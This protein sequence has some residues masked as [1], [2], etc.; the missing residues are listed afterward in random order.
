M[1]TLFD[2]LFPLGMF[3]LGWIIVSWVLYMEF[4]RVNKEKTLGFF[5][6][7]CIVGGCI[8][9]VIYGF[10]LLYIFVIYCIK[11][12]YR[13]MMFFIYVIILFVQTILNAPYWLFTEKFWV[14]WSTT[15]KLENMKIF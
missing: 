7:L 5:K 10:I 1:F 3:I 9:A 12:G 14:N 13:M 11:V 2:I 15:E 4:E 8:T 6:R